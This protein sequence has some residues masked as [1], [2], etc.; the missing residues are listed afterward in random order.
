MSEVVVH[1]VAGIVGSVG[2]MALTYPLLTVSTRLQVQSKTKDEKSSQKHYSGTVDALI[3]IIR[4]EDPTA[5]FSGLNLALTGTAISMGIYYFWYEFFKHLLQKKGIRFTTG[6]SL[7]VAAA[8]GAIN[9]TCTTPFWV[10]T[11]RM[12]NASKKGENEDSS[13]LKT[14]S[15]VWKEAGFGG[16]FRGLM[17]S[18]VLVVNPAIQFMVFEQLRLWLVFQKKRQNLKPVLSATEIFV[19]G[20]IGKIIATIITYPQIVIK[21]RLQAQKSS[22]SSS[23]SSSSPGRHSRQDASKENLIGTMVKLYKAEGFLGFYRGMSSKI[24][25]SVLNSAFMFL[26]KDRSFLLALIILRFFGLSQKQTPLK[27]T[28]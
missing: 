16:F 14:I 13:V 12:Q 23:S 1:C 17:P 5:L 10:I 19:L 8:A 9:T 25:Q 24:V 7:L 22:S 11:T 15:N 6:V 21:T 26:F 20:A 28:Q 3:S 2:A 27:T 18:L 4:D